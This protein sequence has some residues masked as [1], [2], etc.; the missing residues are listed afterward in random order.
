M[1]KYYKK[2][3]RSLDGV[4]KYTND[5]WVDGSAKLITMTHV[6][7]DNHSD[8]YYACIFKKSDTSMQ[9]ERVQHY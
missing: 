8:D 3:F 7:C 5:V 1:E 4:V 2:T 9:F 6:K